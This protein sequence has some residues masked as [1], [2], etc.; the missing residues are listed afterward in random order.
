[1]VTSELTERPATPNLVPV[2]PDFLRRQQE[3][4][5]ASANR[6]INDI[7]WRKPNG[8]I[9]YGPSAIHGSNGRPLTAQAESRIRQGWEPLIE[10]SYT[11]RVSPQTGQRDTIEVSA[12]RLNTP[13]R[14]YWLFANGGAKEFTIEQIVE[15]HWHITPPF[16][17]SRSV[18]PQLEE[19]DVP[20]PRWCPQ[21]PPGRAPM[22]SDDQVTKHLLVVHQPMTAIQAG[23]LLKFA[24]EPPRAAAGVGIRR[25]TREVQEASVEEIAAAEAE[26]NAGRRIICDQCGEEFKTCP[27][28]ATHVKAE[29]SAD[30]S[31]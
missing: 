17:L 20:D 2:P 25:K 23:E 15:H 4:K 12:D 29:H 13:D 8:Y 18:F 24:K 30:A 6:N 1:M 7:Y 10:Y 3:Q 9:T 16:G 21:C 19:W 26:A 11:N 31:P 5:P 22:N 28:R 27:Q 14:W